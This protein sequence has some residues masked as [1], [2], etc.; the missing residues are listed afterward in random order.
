L[1]AR[2]SRKLPITT[3]CHQ[4]IQSPSNAAKSSS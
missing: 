2:V 1:A 4:S 3:V